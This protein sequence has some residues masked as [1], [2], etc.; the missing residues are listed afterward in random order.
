MGRD[1]GIKNRNIVR[2]YKEVKITNNYNDGAY[3]EV[4]TS[5]D[6]KFRVE[7]APLSKKEL[8]FEPVK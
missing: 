7:I 1:G 4:S 6:K 2:E 8:K 5:K 3:V